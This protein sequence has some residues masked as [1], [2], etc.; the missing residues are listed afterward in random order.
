MG[1]EPDTFRTASGVLRENHSPLKDGFKVRYKQ[2]WW[3]Q[4]GMASLKLNYDYTNLRCN[5]FLPS[6]TSRCGNASSAIAIADVG[7]I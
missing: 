7:D 6:Q 3:K 5:R 4:T 1:I 2:F